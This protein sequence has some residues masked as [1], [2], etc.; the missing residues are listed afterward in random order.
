MMNLHSI[1]RRLQAV[2]EG[3]GRPVDYTGPTT[4]RRPPG[5]YRRLQWV[6]VLLASHGFVPETVV[7]L[8]VRGRRS[9]KRRRTVLVRTPYRDEHYLV[10]LAGDSHWVR[11]VRAASG[12][13]VI[14]HGRSEAVR[15]VEVPADQ[16]PPIIRAYLH[17]PGWSNPRGEARRYFGLGP[18]ASPEEIR[19]II[20]RYPVFRI[21]PRPGR[22]ARV[23][24][25]PREV[26][27]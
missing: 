19:R 23:G 4:Y 11:N 12:D 21:A 1:G 27:R 6:G 10:S 17:R 18:D 3:I 25:G 14:R 22:T 24:A 13:A 8:E 16:R 5:L 26:S 15:L 9:G 2:T 20:D 7:A